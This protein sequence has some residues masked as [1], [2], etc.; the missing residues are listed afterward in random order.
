MEEIKRIS[1]IG[2]GNVATL[3]SLALKEKGIQ[4]HQVY[5]RTLAHANLLADKLQAAAVNQ[6][7]YIDD[8]A[9]LYIFCLKD[10]AYSELL[11]EW[12]LK[13][14]NMVH[15]SGSLSSSMF[16]AHSNSRGVFYPFQSFSIDR[17]IDFS[18]I[19]IF[20]D[21][22]SPE[23]L[24][25]LQKLGQKLETKVVQFD[26]EQRKIYHLAAVFANNFVNRL[27][28]IAQEICESE[29]LD[30]DLIR[31]LIKETS[32]KVMDALPSDM[33]T[34]PAKRVDLEL[35][36]IHYSSLSGNLDKQKVYQILSES[37]IKAQKAHD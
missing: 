36:N 6:I 2:S 15:T 4:I 19:P 24:S 8:S 17:E 18:E 28:H 31:P 26:H 29:S 10:D 20:I 22:E 27:Y 25:G 14:K 37:I 23:L 16:A 32:N 30:F 1:I 3:L 34:G 11:S 35:L 13:D 12:T 21:A 5:S 7:K 33:Q 9:D